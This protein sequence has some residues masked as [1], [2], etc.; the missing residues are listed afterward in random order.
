MRLAAV[1]RS[2]LLVGLALVGC[3]DAKKPRRRSARLTPFHREIQ[4]ILDQRCVVCHL[5]KAPQE[6]LV[7]E[8]SHTPASLVGVPSKQSPL[9][10][11]EP[12]KPDK[13]YLL[14]KLR[15]EHLAR[16]GKGKRMPLDAKLPA[17]QLER[18]AR[19]IRSLGSKGLG[20][21]SLGSKRR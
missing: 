10:L 11:V 20:S 9:R 3:S 12:G 5:V 7:L 8:D 14:L 2:L 16:G 19:W 1:C 15:G 13:S 6:K 18:I 4:P 21:K 17:E